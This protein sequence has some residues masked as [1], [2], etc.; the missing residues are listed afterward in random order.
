MLKAKNTSRQLGTIH[1]LHFFAVFTGIFVVMTVII[2]QILWA[3]AYST[4]DKALRNASD[5][6]SYYVRKILTTSALDATSGR[7]LVVSLEL[8]G[9]ILANTEVLIYDKSGNI[10]NF[11]DP[12][13]NMQRITFDRAKQQEIVSR[14]LYNE[15]GQEEIYRTIIVPTRDDY[16]TDV[17]YMALAINVTQLEEANARSTTIIISV[18]L[19]FWILSMG[20]SLYL[21]QWSRK[22]ILLSYEKQ[23]AFVENASHE[24]RTPLAVLQNRLEILF[25]KPD[26]TILENS[27]NIAYSLEEVRNMRVLTS[28]LLDLARRDDGIAV[29]LEELPPHFFK[30]SFEN[31]QLIAEEQDKVFIGTN[32]ITTAFKADPTLLKQLMTILFDNAIKYTNEDGR[33]VFDVA[34]WDKGLFL[35]VADNGYGIPDADKARIFDRFYRVDKA[36]TRQKGGFGLGLSLAKQIVTALNGTITVKDNDPKGTIFEVY[37][38]DK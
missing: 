23:K 21:A 19:I 14:K 33:I 24:L 5:D 22:P 25:R 2:V 11:V 38:T 6:S 36:R 31:Y 16:F 13:S 35:S 12:L 1:F 18:M 7:E 3:G 34:P 30:E 10:M 26:A 17:A 28:N 32:T 27:E 29:Q 4:V 8:K 37:L 9:Q 15:S 20:A